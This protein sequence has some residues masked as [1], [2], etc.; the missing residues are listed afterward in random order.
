MGQV[1][2][3]Q[4]SKKSTNTWSELEEDPEKMVSQKPISKNGSSG[5]EQP[6]STNAR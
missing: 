1:E 5:R 3:E 6:S 4:P 2:K